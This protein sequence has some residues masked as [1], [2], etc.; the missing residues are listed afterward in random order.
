V[1]GTTSSESP[2]INQGALAGVSKGK[3]ALTAARGLEAA[4]ERARVICVYLLFCGAPLFVFPAATD[5]FVRPKYVWISLLTGAL[6]LLSAARAAL[7]TPVRVRVNAP[8]GLLALWMAWNALSIAWARSRSLAWDDAVQWMTILLAVSLALD[9]IGDDRRRLIQLGWGM[10]LAC[11]ATA[12]WTLWQDFVAAFRPQWV[13]VAPR[14]PD[15]RG[16]LSAGLGNT[17]HIADFLALMFVT[18]MLLYLNARRWTALILAGAALALGAAAMVVCWSFHSD[19]GLILACVAVI[20]AIGRR[21]PASWWRRRA[22]RLAV[23]VALFAG[24]AA[25]YLADHRLNPHRPSLWREAFASERWK[26]GGTTRLAIWKPALY[27]AAAN[28]FLGVGAGNFDYVFPSVIVRS[29]QEDPRTMPY[30]GR[31]T[32]AAH[33]EPLQA[34]CELGIVG[35]VLLITMAAVPL[36]TLWRGV[37]EGRGAP[38]TVLIRL[39]LLGFLAAFCV[40]AQMSFNLQLPATSLLFVFA[41]ALAGSLH[42]RGELA[43]QGQLRLEQ[44]WGPVTIEATAASMARIRMAGMKARGALGAILIFGLVAALTAAIWAGAARRLLSD[45]EYARARAAHERLKAM[46]AL[47][48]PDEGDRAETQRRF[49]LALRTNPNHHDCRSAYTVFLMEERRYAEALP[50]IERVMRRL[51]APELYERRAVCRWETGDRKG[52]IEDWLAYYDRLPMAR[53]ADPERYR[54]IEEARRLKE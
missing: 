25:F 1:H 37:A 36:W 41:V 22:L 45:Y 33:N 49:D 5:Q 30:A 28:R 27:M 14:L 39:S 23:I 4:L 3:C 46:A 44:D 48:L 53:A 31:Y 19:A 21:Y 54:A 11:V 20:A 16:F 17:G 38:A 18:N 50:Q 24:V 2:T 13:H 35:F 40:H 6:L 26:E 7:G 12:A 42:D 9:V 8:N 15:W 34:W 29:V 47:G 32:N 43:R 51:D 10:C 52:A